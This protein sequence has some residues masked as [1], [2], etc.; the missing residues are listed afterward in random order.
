M[1]HIP[2]AQRAALHKLERA[3]GP[4][5]LAAMSAQQMARRGVISGGPVLW[6]LTDKGRALIA[7]MNDPA[8]THEQIADL[9][10]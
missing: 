3:S 7:A 9:Y 6:S 5:S 8:L 2:T 1:K 4:V 10:G